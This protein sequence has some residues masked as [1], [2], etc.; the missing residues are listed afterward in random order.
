MSIAKGAGVNASEI[1][2]RLGLRKL[3]T[4]WRGNCPACSYHDT[5]I[6]R[7]RPDQI[8]RVS[9]VSC[10]DLD[11]ITDVLQR[12]TRGEWKPA[13]PRPPE[14]DAE[15]RAEKQRRARALWERSRPDSILAAYLASRGLASLEASTVLRFAP[16]VGYP[17]GGLKLPAMIAR[18]Q[19][20][21]GETVAVHR[22]YLCRDGSGQAG[23]DI[24]KASLGP[25]WGAAIR[26]NPHDPSRPLVVGEGIET[27]A[28]AGIMLQAP[29]WSAIS[30]GNLGAALQLPADVRD[31]VIAA[32]RD[33]EGRSRAG[34]AARRW[35][36]E[37]RTVRIAV[38][39]GSGDWNDALV[40]EIARG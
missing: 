23:V 3:R 7:G 14:G 22:T 13:A 28:S 1:A 8:A 25:V 26:L 27:A 34:Q 2:G 20:V 16:S 15:I 35:Q 17:E 18:V 29:A 11:A 39:T 36:Q 5:F 19:D 6:V 10:N 33:S 21:D 38:P 32:D 12:V 40:R 9:C 24:R 30:A 31:I 37:G 4:Q